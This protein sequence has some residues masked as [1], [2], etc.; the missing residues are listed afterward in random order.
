MPE[1]A[2]L[3]DRERVDL[4]RNVRRRSEVLAVAV[5]RLDV[6]QDCRV[7][8]T[9]RE[10]RVVRAR[11]L[12]VRRE[13]AVRAEQGDVALAGRLQLLAERLG[14]RSELPRDVDTLG[15]GRDLRDHGRE[16]RSLLADR[17]P[18]DGHAVLFEDRLHA[19]GQALG[20]R[21]LVVDDVD[22]LPLQRLDHVVGDPGSLNTV[23]RDGAV[24]VPDPVPVRMAV[25]ERDP[26]RRARDEAETAALIGRCR[27]DDLLAAGGADYGKHLRVRRERVCHLDR[28]RR[29]DAELGVAR[30]DLD[31][32]ALVLPVPARGPIL[33]PVKL[34]HADRRGRAGER[35]RDTNRA[36]LA[37]RD[38]RGRCCTHPVG[39]L[40]R[41][42]GGGRDGD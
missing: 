11:D 39:T 31:P 24:E 4:R 14:L 38:F 2:R 12:P 20:V 13:E 25:G 5:V 17:V 42:P 33:R 30:D 15:V 6:G 16:V 35:G 21:L 9:D 26:R 19:V 40:G 41:A 37:A 3:R 23:V 8:R 34:F 32:R 22:A 27:G 28:E 29:V 10:E 36:D 7:R 1:R 18:G